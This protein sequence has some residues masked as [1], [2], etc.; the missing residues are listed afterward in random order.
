MRPIAT[1]LADFEALRKAGTVYVDQIRA[2][3]YAGPCLADG[4]PV[5][6]IGLGFDAVEEIKN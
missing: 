5:H 3:G 6:A 1:N 2:K 4:R